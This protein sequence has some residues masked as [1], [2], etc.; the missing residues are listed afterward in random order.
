M[1]SAYWLLLIKEQLFAK[2]LS[3][4]QAGEMN[5]DVAWC[6]ESLQSDHPAGKV[7]NRNRLTHV[8]NEQITTPCDPACLNHQRGSLVYGHAIPGRIGVGNGDRATTFDLVRECGNCA[9]R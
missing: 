5:L 7:Q 3:G 2:L 4:P 9:S 6:S 1:V 8:E